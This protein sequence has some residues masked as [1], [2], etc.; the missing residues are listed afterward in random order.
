MASSVE[1]PASLTGC[2]GV[3]SNTCFRSVP[4][5][6][7]QRLQDCHVRLGADLQKAGVLDAA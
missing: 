4:E 5:H 6:L 3:G 1:L 2:S 7:L